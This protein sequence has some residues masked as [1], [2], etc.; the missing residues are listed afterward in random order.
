MVDG[1][2]LHF[3]LAGINNQNF[4]MQDE[5]TKT[6]WQQISGEAILGPLK[7]RRLEAIAWDEV[8]FAVWKREYPSGLVLQGIEK[9]RSKYATPDWDVKILKRPTVTPVDPKDPLKPRDLIV[10]VSVGQDTK[11][12]PLEELKKQNPIVDKLGSTLILLVVDSDGKSVRGFNRELEGQALDLFLK[13]GSNPLILVDSQT[14]TEWDF[15]GKAI[16]GPM[17][18]KSLARI[19]T[20]KDFWFDWKLYNPGTK[21]FRAGKLEKAIDRTTDQIII[22]SWRSNSIQ[23]DIST[24]RVFAR[25]HFPLTLPSPP[26]K[27]RSGVRVVEDR[28]RGR[29][30]VGLVYDLCRSV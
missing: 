30:A 12:Y 14:G 10:G 4:I 16:T 9:Y 27:T 17:T 3:R 29:C 15:S 6:W 5:E 28:V 21:V 2:T 1:R 18:G 8:S 11:A 22:H 20:L 13:P 24:C 26:N 25:R 23:S 19:Q 7:G